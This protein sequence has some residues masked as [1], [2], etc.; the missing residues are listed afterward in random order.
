[1]RPC[2]PNNAATAADTSSAPAAST[3]VVCAAAAV[4]AASIADPR[5]VRLLAA[6]ASDSGAVITKDISIPNQYVATNDALSMPPNDRRSTINRW[7]RNLSSSR[8]RGPGPP[9]Q[10]F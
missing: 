3:V 4:F 8:G 2:A 1:M 10:W 5:L 7:E 9:S 6:D